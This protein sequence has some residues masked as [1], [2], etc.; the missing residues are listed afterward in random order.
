MRL[1]QQEVEVN[2]IGDDKVGRF[3]TVNAAAYIIIHEQDAAQF[4]RNTKRLQSLLKDADIAK[5]VKDK[6]L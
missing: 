1:A 6:G 5:L 3:E 4:V 2:V